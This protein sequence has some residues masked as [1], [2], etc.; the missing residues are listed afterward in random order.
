MFY[1]GS[2]GGREWYG[3][4]SDVHVL[5]TGTFIEKSMIPHHGFLKTW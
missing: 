3:G 2:G 5:G 4:V 1:E